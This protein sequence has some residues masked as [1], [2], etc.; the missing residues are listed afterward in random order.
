MAST[1]IDSVGTAAPRAG[2]FFARVLERMAEG[3]MRKARAAAR[4]HLLALDDEA[5]AQLGYS[6]D[7]I[8]RWES[9]SNS[10]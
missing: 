8:R 6:R 1:T 3:P 2:G 10:I 5:L 4:P 7:E 9:L